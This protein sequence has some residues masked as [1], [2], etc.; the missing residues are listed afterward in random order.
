M[1]TI[2]QH[3]MVEPKVQTNKTIKGLVHL[4]KVHKEIVKLIFKLFRRDSI[5]L[6]DEQIQFRLLFTYNFLN[7]QCDGVMEGL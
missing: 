7:R 2:E 6:Y 1:Y 4:K 3:S 5:D